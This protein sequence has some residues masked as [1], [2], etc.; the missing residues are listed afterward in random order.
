MGQNILQTNKDIPEELEQLILGGLFGDGS[1]FRNNHKKINCKLGIRYKE[2]HSLK[3]KDYS[4]WKKSIFSKYIGMGEYYNNNNN[5]IVFFCKTSDIFIEFYKE[6]Y[7]EQKGFKKFSLVMLNRLKPLGL[8]V[9]YMDDGTLSRHSRT[10]SFALDKR[11]S[12]L[13]KIWFKDK[14]NIDSKLYTNAN[15]NSSI[16]SFN[17]KST[18]I[19]IS[20]IREFI[21]PSM[22]YKIDIS[23]E[24]IIKVR[25]E[26]KQWRL[27]NPEKVKEYSRRAY[28]CN[29]NHINLY[30]KKYIERPEN[31]T[32]L[33]EYAKN[34]AKEYYLNNKERY[35]KNIKLKGE[36]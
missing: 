13:T 26:A 24:E 31:K 3:Q 15:S 29:K 22:K 16:L 36:D 25:G 18:D 4:L 20:M 21:H 8:A 2:S 14:F 7:P 19:I 6:F 11:N 10:I 23:E 30:H 9:W 12:E 33:K 34:Y 28:I 17:K 1:L 27:K 5:A 32:R 35:Y